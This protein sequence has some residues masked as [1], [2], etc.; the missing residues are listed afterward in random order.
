MGPTSKRREG[1]GNEKGEGKGRGGEGKGTEGKRKEMDKRERPYAPP[2]ANSWR[3]HWIQ[4]AS[5]QRL[6][7]SKGVSSQRN[8][9]NEFMN[10]RTY[11]TETT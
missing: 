3:G 9:C 6:S 8:V 11:A 4:W 10:L 7:T 2:V 5:V 1:N